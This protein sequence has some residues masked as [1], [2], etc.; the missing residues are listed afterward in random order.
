MSWLLPVSAV[1]ARSQTGSSD[2][3]FA[4]IVFR[5]RNREFRIL[6]PVPLLQLPGGPLLII[7]SNLFTGSKF[8]NVSDIKLFPI[9]ISLFQFSSPQY[10]RD[11]ITI[12]PSR[13]TRSSDLITLLRPPVQS[14]LRITNRSFRHMLHLSCGTNFLIP[15]G[16][17]TSLVH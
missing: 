1:A 17:L 9:L 2:D 6:S 4:V 7:F 3:P 16:S 15:F 5:I 13:S 10:L 12:Q 14:R 11:T 8:R